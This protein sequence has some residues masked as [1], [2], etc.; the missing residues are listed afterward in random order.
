MPD[1]PALSEL[2]FSLTV[3][4][5]VSSQLTPSI[6]PWATLILSRS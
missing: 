4:D 5:S 1:N 6:M 2:R 3:W